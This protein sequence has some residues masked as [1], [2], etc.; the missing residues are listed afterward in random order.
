MLIKRIETSVIKLNLMFKPKEN[1]FWPFEFFFDRTVCVAE[2]GGIEFT[3]SSAG[4]LV[5]EVTASL[6]MSVS[7]FRGDV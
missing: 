7:I 6:R 2:L 4:R 5:A 1:I 3:A